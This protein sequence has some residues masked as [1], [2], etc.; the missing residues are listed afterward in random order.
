MTDRHDARAREIGYE[1]REQAL[2]ADV[3]ALV[4]A[5]NQIMREA[6]SDPANQWCRNVLA[7]ATVAVAR[8]GVTGEGR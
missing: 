3:L 1:M 6:A 2:R 8:P 4:K 5:L 7:I